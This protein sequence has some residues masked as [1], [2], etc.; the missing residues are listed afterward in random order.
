MTCHRK[1]VVAWALLQINRPQRKVSRRHDVRRLSTLRRFEPSGS[2]AGLEQRTHSSAVE[3]DAIRLAIAAHGGL[4]RTCGAF[5]LHPYEARPVS[6]THLRAH[7]TDS[8]L[9]CR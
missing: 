1:S 5:G 8:Y 2:H 6:Y 7:E 4:L 3:H 9:V